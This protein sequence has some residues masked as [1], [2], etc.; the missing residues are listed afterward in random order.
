LPE[1]LAAARR[2]LLLGNGEFGHALSGDIRL[3]L[4]Q[5]KTLLHIARTECLEA[6]VAASTQDRD[7]FASN[8]SFV[9]TDDGY[10]LCRS[11]P[12]L[13]VLRFD[14]Q[15]AW[16]VWGGCEGIDPSCASARPVP[17][18]Q[19]AVTEEPVHTGGGA[20]LAADVGTVPTSQ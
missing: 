19:G 9:V 8:L 15:G 11:L 17:C 5:G 13:P 20:R 4:L 16:N 10:E 14:F 18:L 7:P 3:G 2:Y 6:L 12:S 1:H